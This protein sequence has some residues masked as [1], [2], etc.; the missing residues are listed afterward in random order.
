MRSA[1]GGRL[2]ERGRFNF[3]GMFT[4]VVDTM[5]QLPLR[6]DNATVYCECA[7]DRQ[8]LRSLHED[9][10]RSSDSRALSRPRT[11]KRGSARGICFRLWLTIDDLM[12]L[13]EG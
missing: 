11:S 1:S 6:F 12:T 3:G 2:G 13:N 8:M 7:T 5:Q 9:G 10:R 4:D